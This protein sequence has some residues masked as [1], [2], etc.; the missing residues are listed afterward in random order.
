MMEHF[1]VQEF[2]SQGAVESLI[3]PVLPRGSRLDEPRGHFL[4]LQ[5]TRQ[6]FG[7]ELRAVVRPQI[8]WRSKH[9]EQ[10]AHHLDDLDMTETRVYFHCQTNPAVLFDHRQK[11]QFPS[12]LAEIMHK[13]TRPDMVPVF[14]SARHAS[15]H[16]SAL[17]LRAHFSGQAM[18]TA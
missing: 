17:P 13:I 9:P 7:D 12:V 1:L 8:L 3:P 15:P 10:I 18:E 5:P 14:R 2:I 16:P 6:S 4:F 11:P